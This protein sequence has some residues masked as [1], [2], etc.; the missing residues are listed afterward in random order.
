MKAM[1]HAVHLLPSFGIHLEFLQLLHL[2]DRLPIIMEDRHSVQGLGVHLVTVIAQSDNKGVWVEYDLHV[3]HLLN[4]TICSFDRECDEVFPIVSLESWWDCVAGSLVT[5]FVQR[6]PCSC[7]Y[8]RSLVRIVRVFQDAYK[9]MLSWVE[10]PIGHVAGC[11][12]PQAACCWCTDWCSASCAA[13]FVLL[14]VMAL[15]NCSSLHIEHTF[16]MACCDLL[17]LPKRDW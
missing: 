17:W 12:T 2:V 14:L 7:D 10:F 4:L 11:T 6:E 3:L 13:I 15:A 9:W 1:D 5:P 8:V 16:P